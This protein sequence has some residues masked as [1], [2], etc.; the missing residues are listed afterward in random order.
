[1]GSRIDLR[2]AGA[3]LKENRHNDSHYST[4][5]FSLRRRLRRPRPSDHQKLFTAGRALETELGLRPQRLRARERDDLPQ[6]AADYEAQQGVDSFARWARK[7]LSPA[8]RA[9]EM[10]SWDELHRTCG[11]FGVILRLHG[12]GL[13]FED[14]ERGIRVKASSVG[15]E[16][17]KPRLCKRLAHRVGVAR[18]LHKAK[19]AACRWHDAYAHLLE[20]EAGIARRHADIG[21]KRDL[22]AKREA[23][24]MRRC[25][26][27]LSAKAPD[28]VP[29]VH[30]VVAHRNISIVNAFRLSGR[31]NFTKP[32]EPRFSY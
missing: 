14:A 1:M 4:T 3:P 12:N 26:H 5:S 21:A 23:S 28:D 16:L 17:S 22:G 7:T 31:L 24:P 10:H 29:W 9:T 8:L 2:P 32:M 30:R 20:A 18:G 13:V 6:R 15:R 25:D 19:G 27:G 11:H